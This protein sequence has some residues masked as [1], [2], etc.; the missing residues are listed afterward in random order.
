MA[1]LN[2]TDGFIFH[3][4][5]VNEL[6][7]KG[8][9][10]FTY[11]VINQFSQSEAGIYKGGVPYLCLWTGWSANTIRK[12]LRN[13]EQSGLIQSERGNINGVP[14]C[15]YK[16]T[17]LPT[18][19][20][21]KDTPQELK[22]NPSEIEVSTLQNLK[23]TTLQNLSGDNNSRKVKGDSKRGSGGNGFVKPTVKEIKEYADSIGFDLDAEYFFDFY[24]RAGWT[25]GKDRKPVKSWKA[26]LRLWKRQE[27]SIKTD[28]ESPKA[29]SKSKFDFEIL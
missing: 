29:Q 10:L 9:E 21:L 12:Y 18:L 7:L 4:W 22:G 28:A 25:Y 16:S 15:Y 27:N 11:A 17:P 1:H 2:N 23:D 20:N 3:G 8:G 19:Q 6:K 5:M 13:L 14:F 24:E 26:C